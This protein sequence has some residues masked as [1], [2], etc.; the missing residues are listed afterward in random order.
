MQY[1]ECIFLY[2]QDKESRVERESYR[3]VILYSVE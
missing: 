2:G 3:L 1:C